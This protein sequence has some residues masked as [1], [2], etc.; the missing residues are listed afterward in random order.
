VAEHMG[1]KFEPSRARQ[2]GGLRDR[3]IS[4]MSTIARIP[5][6]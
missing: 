1:G 4:T 6:L 2:L 5:Q 3:S